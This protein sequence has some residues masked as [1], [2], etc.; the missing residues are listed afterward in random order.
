MSGGKKQFSA[1]NV[2]PLSTETARRKSVPL[3]RLPA[4]MHAVRERAQRDLAER[5]SKLFE[6]ADDALFKLA[7]QATNNQEQNLYFESMREVRIQRRDIEAGFFETIDLGF[8]ALLNGG[9]PPLDEIPT[10]S[11]EVSIDNLSL[12]NNEDLEELVAIDSMVRRASKEYATPIEHLNIRANYLLT[13]EVHSETNPIAPPTLCRSFSAASERLNIDIKAKLVLFKL[14]DKFVMTDLAKVYKNSNTVLVEHN[15]QPNLVAE[16]QQARRPVQSPIQSPIQ[17][18][19]Q[20]AIQSPAMT[21]VASGAQGLS[22]LG[23]SQAG[24]NHSSMAA[25][26][27]Q[28][29]QIQMGAAAGG[30]VNLHD[31]F[32]A[33]SFNAKPG[34]NT[35]VSGHVQT[36][37]VISALN[38][39]QH[40]AQT[41]DNNGKLDIASLLSH[42][43]LAQGQSQELRQMD[44]DVINLVNLL[45]DYILED[46]NL[47][48]VMKAQLARLQIPLLKVALADKTFFS[49]GGHPA[50][51]LLN[52]MASAGLGWHNTDSGSGILLTKI[53][54]L[55][56]QVLE[57]YE[58]DAS[59]FT[60]LLTDFVSFTEKEQRRAALL[61]QRIIDA[62]SGKAK[63]ESARESVQAT[64]VDVVAGQVLPQSVATLINEAWGNVLLLV[65]LKHGVESQH[66]SDGVDTAKDIVWSVGDELGQDGRS[67]LLKIL[68]SLLKRIRLGLESIS[69]N[70]FEMQKLLQELETLHLGQLTAK[71]KVSEAAAQVSKPVILAE[72]LLKE[73]LL[74]E[75]S[76]KE[77]PLKQT[78]SEEALVKEALIK[79]APVNAP[80]SRVAQPD[81]QEGAIVQ[82]QPAAK[83]LNE[84]PDALHASPVFA[85]PVFLAEEVPLETPDQEPSQTSSEEEDTEQDEYYL[86]QVDR[87]TQGAWFEMVEDGGQ[88]YRCRL[89]AIIKS[90][91]KYIF[92]NRSGNKVA[93][94]TR[95][96]LAK[97]LELGTINQL[98]DGMLFD[99]ALESVIGNL[100][101]SRSSVG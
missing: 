11:E 68:P 81:L 43:L 84:S 75:S 50:R 2:V 40:Q 54:K 28:D 67:R 64:L 48:A 101:A 32:S 44:S 8:A 87:L 4:P 17:S 12:V 53:T 45:F 60:E 15:V 14:F 41:S 38:G 83:A 25:G 55:V 27:P 91:G 47:D 18:P 59:I 65:C 99:R 13:G 86:G 6:Q 69:Y 57:G 37:D 9:A 7:D 93:E 73:S 34:S 61:E 94:K 3:T 56:D 100:R 62:E 74:K 29:M 22:E 85:K 72:T 78:L 1:S 66:W 30:V 39:L 10:V 76:L 24:M 82:P 90:A 96:T 98:D 89:A 71:P 79:E 21:P 5:L 49:H 26:A 36:P 92:V 23:M 33:N 51:R 52:E 35:G 80:S 88:A 97:A 42:Y 70:P 95:A 16:L 58:S 19:T 31:L 63:S 77:A 46:S 20:P